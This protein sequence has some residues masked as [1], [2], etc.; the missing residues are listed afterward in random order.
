MERYIY[1]QQR[2][3]PYWNIWLCDDVALLL[4]V[5]SFT[6]GSRKEVVGTLCPLAWTTAMWSSDLMLG[7]VLLS[8]GLIARSELGIG[9]L[10]NWAG[11]GSKVMSLLEWRNSVVLFICYLLW[12]LMIRM[13]TICQF[14]L[15]QQ[16]YR[17]QPLSEIQD[18]MNIKVIGGTVPRNNCF[19]CLFIHV[20]ISPLHVLALTGHLQGEYTIIFWKLPH[21]NGS[22][23]FVL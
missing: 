9:T 16:L 23:V 7:L 21:Y 17:V 10:S 18:V 2:L 8:L 14:Q 20:F 22:V 12:L 19:R 4:Q 15:S 1:Q 11:L 13:L 3:L 5:W 6:M